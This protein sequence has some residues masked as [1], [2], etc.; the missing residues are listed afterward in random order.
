M[1]LGLKL[2]GTGLCWYPVAGFDTG[3]SVSSEFT[4]KDGRCDTDPRFLVSLGLW[5]WA[6]IS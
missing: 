4:G 3:A 5:M 6:G 1:F 2:D